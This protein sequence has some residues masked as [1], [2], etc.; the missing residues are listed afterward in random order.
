[1]ALKTF[2]C[3]AHKDK[4]LLYRL[5]IHL[6]PL[7]RQGL[8][9]MC[10]DGDISAG[11]EWEPEITRYLKV[12]QVILLLVSPDFIASDYCYSVEMQLAIERH[13]QEEV[14]VIPIILRSSFWRLTPLV[15]LQALPK[16]A[17]PVIGPAWR[18]QDEA[19]FNVSEGICAAVEKILSLPSSKS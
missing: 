19:F 10:Y 4:Q 17:K 14:C 5:K 3:Y 2:F 7:Q 9:D 16:D 6:K 13:R 8:I 1:M 15:N 18:N 11:T 12:A